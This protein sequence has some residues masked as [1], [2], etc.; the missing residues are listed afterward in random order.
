MSDQPRA[1]RPRTFNPTGAFITLDDIAEFVQE[2]SALGMPGSSVV[3]ARPAME[4][5]L[6]HGARVVAIT[7]VPPVPE[8][9]D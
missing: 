6:Q 4:I 1:P 3:R 7:A 2:M 8:Q 9:D 5:D